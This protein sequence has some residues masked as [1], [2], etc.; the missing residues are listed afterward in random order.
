MRRLA[1]GPGRFGESRKPALDGED[2]RLRFRLVLMYPESEQTDL[3]EE[4]CEDDTLGDHL[5]A[6]F[7]PDALPLPWDAAGAYTRG[8]LDVY[9]HTHLV[10]PFTPKQLR[11]W[12]A[13]G[14]P[15][16]SMYEET[17]AAE[18]EPASRGGREARAAGP[19]LVLVDQGVAMGEVLAGTGHVIAGGTVVLF[20]LSRGTPFATKFLISGLEDK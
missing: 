1:F 15:A 7:G 2:G 18:D 11:R 20:V 10:P 16:S 8:Q 6:M 4:M 9:Y 14:T 3:I 13:E 5:D 19:K 17:H 12:L